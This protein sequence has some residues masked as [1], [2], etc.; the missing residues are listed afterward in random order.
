MPFATG[1]CVVDA[2][3]G[4]GLFTRRFVKSGDYGCVVA[5]DFATRC[6]GRRGPLPEEGLVDAPLDG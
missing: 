3:C 6:F 5:L 4:S 2:S 1:K